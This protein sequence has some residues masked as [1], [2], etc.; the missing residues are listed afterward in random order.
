VKGIG[1]R[2]FAGK[3]RAH[4]AGEDLKTIA[5]EDICRGT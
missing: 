1:L 2:L 3:V 5:I 4:I